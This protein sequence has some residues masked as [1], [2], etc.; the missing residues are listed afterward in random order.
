MA[1]WLLIQPGRL[2]RWHLVACVAAV[3][4]VIAPWYMHVPHS[5]A[6]W[7]V[8]K[9]WH[10]DSST[11]GENQYRP[12]FYFVR[13]ALGP[14]SDILTNWWRK[15]AF[16]TIGL[17]LMTWTGRRAVAGGRL[18]VW[19]WWLGPVLGLFVF[20]A[21]EDTYTAAV[22]RYA[23]ASLPATMLLVGILMSSLPRRVY[24][25]LLGLMVIASLP[26]M[27]RLFT[28]EGRNSWYRPV[29]RLLDQRAGPDQL[30]LVHSIPSGILG[31]A[32]YTH[33]TTALALWTQQLR[34]LKGRNNVNAIAADVVK[35]TAGWR[36]V[37]VVAVH[38]VN[39]PSPE[40]DY[41]RQH[42]KLVAESRAGNAQVAEFLPTDGG[43][44]TWP[45]TLQNAVPADAAAP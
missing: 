38:D 8:T 23:L 16:A 33:A 20:D 28:S 11:V 21:L 31:I 10:K 45:A 43:V 17:A 6:A 26:A 2:R 18:L 32:R 13:N 44:F 14:L 39:E 24:V 42:A 41:L 19:F 30:V 5:L 3:A 4:V 34:K 35:L 9:D 27:Y 1:L 15:A 37:F 12:F 40:L 25:P 36:K 22:P 29:A 7:R